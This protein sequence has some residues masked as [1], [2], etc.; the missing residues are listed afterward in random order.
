MFCTR[1]IMSCKERIFMRAISLA[2]CHN[3]LSVSVIQLFVIGGAV[4]H[5][6]R[7]NCYQMGKLIGG[8][9]VCLQMDWKQ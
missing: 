9:L 4:L 3:M 5:V 8:E 7:L 6:R 1:L 2:L